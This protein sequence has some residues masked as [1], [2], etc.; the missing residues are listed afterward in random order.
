M[1]NKTKTKFLTLLIIIFP[2]IYLGTWL[3]KDIPPKVNPNIDFFKT[4][5][6]KEFSKEEMSKMWDAYKSSSFIEKL[7]FR[8]YLNAR[9]EA[10]LN[11]CLAHNLGNN[12]GGGC[13]HFVGSY[14]MN[15]TYFALK[16]CGINWK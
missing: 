9:D 4:N 1:F 6:L 15:D 13:H 2:I 10:I 8:K 3:F 14:N 16:Y 7:Y 11:Y 5:E 12:I